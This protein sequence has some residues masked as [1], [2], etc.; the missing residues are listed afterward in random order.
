MWSMTLLLLL[1]MMKMSTTTTFVGEQVML[2][3]RVVRHKQ[4][5]QL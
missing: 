5:G 3:A 1:L 4:V 2:I